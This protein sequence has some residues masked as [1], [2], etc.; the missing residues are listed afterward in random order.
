MITTI[1]EWILYLEQAY[2]NRVAFQYMDYTTGELTKI[3]YAR[4]AGD[5]RQFASY[6]YTTIK[7]PKGKHFG[8]LAGNGYQYAVSLYGVLLAG[9]VAVPLNPMK[10]C[11]KLDYEIT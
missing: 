11:E 9:G 10:S 6:L 5:V 7:D 2:P 8:I 3:T 4:Y 1:Q